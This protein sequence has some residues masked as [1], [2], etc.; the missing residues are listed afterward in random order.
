MSEAKWKGDGDG[1][2]TK[3]KT[4]I[5]IAATMYPYSAKSICG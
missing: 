1:K 4:T 5:S 2:P 3:S